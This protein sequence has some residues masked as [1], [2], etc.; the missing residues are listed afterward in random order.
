VNAIFL[1]ASIV[2]GAPALKDPPKKDSGIVGEWVVES[3][4]LGGKAGKVA[5]TLR[6]EFTADG[7]WIIR[8]DG[9]AVKAVPRQYKVNEKANP[10]TIDITYQKDGAGGQ[11]PDML[12][13]YKIDGDTLTL[14]YTPGGGE[15]PTTFEPADGVKVA[16]L[17]LKRV[18]KK[19]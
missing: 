1:A 17:V 18:K 15:R 6:Y 19:D 14:C 5:S 8:R 4:M 13:I 16:V 2:V 12:G 9:A 10:A 7:Q 11:P 3:T